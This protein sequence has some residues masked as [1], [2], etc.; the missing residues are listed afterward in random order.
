MR[1]ELVG[2]S[3]GHRVA[4]ASQGSKVAQQGAD[5]AARE[6]PHRLDD[7]IF[8]LQSENIR[9]CF[10]YPRTSPLCKIRY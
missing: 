8:L 3:T 2:S 1:S 6:Q 7:T 10:P 5:A 9:Y 4:S